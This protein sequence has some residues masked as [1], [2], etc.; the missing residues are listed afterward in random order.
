MLLH[1]EEIILV[2]PGR[3]PVAPERGVLLGFDRLQLFE[4]FRRVIFRDGQHLVRVCGLPSLEADLDEDR[5]PISLPGREVWY[6]HDDD[7]QHGARRRGGTRTGRQGR[8]R[9]IR[10]SSRDSS[11]DVEGQDRGGRVDDVFGRGEHP[12]QSAEQ[13]EQ[14]TWC[15]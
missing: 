13:S 9:T 4:H 5:V 8:D 7:D 10:H 14:H 15:T 2:P 6:G 12:T 11:W 1:F 3:S